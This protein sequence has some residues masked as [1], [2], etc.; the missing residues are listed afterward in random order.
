M[1]LTSAA[2]TEDG[3]RRAYLQDQM[4]R[5]SRSFAVVVATLEEPMRGFLS[6][7]YLL[8]RV[9]DN[10]EDCTQPHDW[11]E[12]RFAEYTAL[13]QD[14]GEALAV[15]DYWEHLSWPGLTEDERKLMGAA[16]GGP[17]WSIYGGIPE[18]ERAII[19]RWCQAMATGMSS[20]ENPG[21]PPLFVQRLGVRVAADQEDYDQYCYVV[22]GTVGHMASELA[23]RQFSLNGDISARLREDAEA[24]GRA[25]Q[26]TNILKDFARDLQR[27]VCFLPDTWL[28]ETEY[29]PLALRGAPTS[30]VWRVLVNLLD[31]LQATCRYVTA[32][33][34]QAASYRMACLL[35]FLPAFQTNLLAAT[36]HE[37]LFTSNHDYKISRATMARCA[38]DARGMITDN[39]RV[40]AYAKKVESEIQ[41]ALHRLP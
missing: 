38:V 35:S 1:Q 27:G 39:D 30:F 7:A 34:P 25:L 9:A 16:T 41:Q 3:H 12:E 2:S 22:A 31:E 24:C 21:R 33:P 14:P 28:R 6:T 18:A 15:L 29:A 23:I 20:V 19:S 37:R 36:A 4:S 17:L 5:V 13:L 8:C 10:I 40:F 32:L 11:R 26:K